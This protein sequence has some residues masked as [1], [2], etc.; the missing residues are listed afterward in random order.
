MRALVLIAGLLSCVV[1]L[2]AEGV[3][4]DKSGSDVR[5][6][7]LASADP[8]TPESSTSVSG[9]PAVASKPTKTSKKVTGFTEEREAAAM[10]FVRL[11]HPELA[12]LLDQLKSS[13]NAEYQRAIRDLFRSS[14][15]L[16]QVEERN[17]QRYPHELALW[18][19]NSRI[20]LLVARL[21]MTGDD[22]LKDELRT[23][24]RDRFESRKALI[25]EERG[26]L[27][28]K[29]TELNA[30][31]ADIQQHEAQLI[32]QRMAKLLD[33]ASKSRTQLKSARASK[34][35]KTEKDKPAREPSSSASP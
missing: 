6:P 20:Q 22:S 2:A 5:G 14:E 15:R 11:N 10:T 21:A 8:T 16:A 4:R 33:D 7:L 30:E 9:K 3:V 23:A 25:D 35:A 34:K 28:A 31:Y 17:P 13:D 29:L 32:D 19:L 18:K 12:D 26:R 24:L 27:Q 1:A